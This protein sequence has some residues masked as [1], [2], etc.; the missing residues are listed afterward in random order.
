MRR[1]TPYAIPCGSANIRRALRPNGKEDLPAHPP[2]TAF[3]ASVSYPLASI[4][5][6]SSASS[7]SGLRSRFSR[8]SVPFG[9][10]HQWEPG[11][12]GRARRMSNRALH[13]R[14]A[15]TY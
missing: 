1:P 6:T 2:I 10:A 12:P 4:A 3:T 15:L 11:R 5:G 9:G 14:C 8:V 13:R 7:S